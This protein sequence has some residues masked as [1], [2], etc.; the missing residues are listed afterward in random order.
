MQKC[1][2]KHLPDI[3]DEDFICPRCSAE[4]GVW[5]IE[6]SHSDDC[7]HLADIDELHCMSCNHRE[8]AKA[9]VKKWKHDKSLITC[10]HCKGKGVI[11]VVSIV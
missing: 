10:P 5:Y 6:E 7:E 2:E 3:P 9:F 1:E 8:S 4:M 11:V